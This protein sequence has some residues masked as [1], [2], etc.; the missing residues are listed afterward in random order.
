MGP[1]YTV[2]EAQPRQTG[3]SYI[4]R[5]MHGTP[6]TAFFLWLVVEASMVVAIRTDFWIPSIPITTMWLTL[7]T[8]LVGTGLFVSNVF[9]F[10]AASKKK[11]QKN[12][13]EVT[14]ISPLGKWDRIP[15]AAGDQ[16]IL[17]A[18]TASRLFVFLFMIPFY[19]LLG[20][21]PFQPLGGG[22][23]TGDQVDQ[24]GVVRFFEESIL[25][26]TGVAVMIVLAPWGD[27]LRRYADSKLNG[28]QDI[29]FDAVTNQASS[30]G[31]SG[32]AE[33]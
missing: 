27:T 18:V 19:N 32:L 12:V 2:D 10:G 9:Y 33:F 5:S 3:G 25:A 29:E 7:V 24:R 14:A 28:D 21:A 30:T 13:S 17:T 6:G 8:T 16:W 15:R 23:P 11:K 20:N 4:A 26:T 31:T 1:K 22:V